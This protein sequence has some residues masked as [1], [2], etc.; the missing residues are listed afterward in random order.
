[1][2]KEIDETMEWDIRISTLLQHIEVLKKPTS[3][4]RSSVPS[5]RTEQTEHIQSSPVTGASAISEEDNG[6][7]SSVSSTIGVRLPKIELPKFNG[8]ITQFNS[9]WQAFN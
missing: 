8:D 9:F 6:S 5:T 2:G 1:M 3:L 4:S 7:F